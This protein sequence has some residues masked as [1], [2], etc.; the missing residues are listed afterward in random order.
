MK[1]SKKEF[2]LWDLVKDRMQTS[3]KIF[4]PQ[5]YDEY[6]R[7]VHT[8]LVDAGVEMHLRTKECGK[9]ATKEGGINGYTRQRRDCNSVWSCPICRERIIDRYRVKYNQICWDHLSKGGR[10]LLITFNP[11]R[12]K[13]KKGSLVN[14]YQ[15]FSDAMRYLREREP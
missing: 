7:A 8:S 5:T 14:Q 12:D 15:S 4:I 2:H 13:H 3:K 1:K 9:F 10:T 6:L 11:H